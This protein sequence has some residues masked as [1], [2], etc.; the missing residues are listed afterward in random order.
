MDSF[1]IA[2]WKEPVSR[3]DSNIELHELHEAGLV[4]ATVNRTAHSDSTRYAIDVDDPEL[5]AH[6][7]RIVLAKSASNKWMVV[8]TLNNLEH[9]FIQLTDAI[10]NAESSTPPR[11]DDL[12]S[13]SR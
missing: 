11:Q 12:R 6:Y 4:H 2:F 7:G 3:D 13:S 5:K 1:T 8:N 10:E 9:I